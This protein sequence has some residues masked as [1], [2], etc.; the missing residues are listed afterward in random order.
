M[1]MPRGPH[2]PRSGFLSALRPIE[3]GTEV[4]HARSLSQFIEWLTA[5][6]LALSINVLV[7][8]P[9]VL[10]AL[11]VAYGRHLYNLGS[12]LYMYLML[13]TGIQRSFPQIRIH[14][15]AAWMLA[16]NWR[17]AEPVNHR[18]PVP[19]ALYKAIISV[20]LLM[21]LNRFAG[22]IVLSYNG[23]G[24][25]GE[26]LRA[27]RKSLV[28]PCDLLFDP[29]NLTLLSIKNPKSR[30]RGGAAT[31]HISIRSHELS[32]FLER[33][34]ASLAPDVNLY[35]LS[36]ATFRSRW[37]LVLSRLGVPRSMFTPGGLRG[38]GAVSAYMEGAHISDLLCR[39]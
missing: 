23:P 6:G 25:I 29:S 26:I 11:I 20:A 17:L 12:P 22:C 39:L 2:P 35:P 34:F 19:R 5:L 1:N 30:H 15:H 18:L 38:G 28:V 37:D 31:Q 7:E 10:D 24:R 36:P 4:L 21:N 33:V 8:S 3:P 16:V 32:R 14:L 13:V 9:S 27:H